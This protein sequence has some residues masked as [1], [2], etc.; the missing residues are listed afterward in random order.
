MAYSGEA[1]EPDV[2]ALAQLY[3]F[4]TVPRQALSELCRLAP[5]VR[6]DVG[7]TLFRQGDPSDYALLLVGGRLHAFIHAGDLQRQVGDVRPGEIVGEGALFNPSG[8][9]SATVVTVESSSALRLDASILEAAPTNSAV[10]ALEQ[11]LLGTVARRIRKTNQ[12]MLQEWRA[13]AM[14]EQEPKKKTA[15]LKDR[16]LSMLGWS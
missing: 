16:L 2:G 11:Y 12:T 10:V 4:H 8:R 5:P 6:F 14:L 7:E 13:E 9:R 3:L 1:M 15:S